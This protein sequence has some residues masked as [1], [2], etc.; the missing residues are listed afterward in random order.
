MAV[1]EGRKLWFEV[2]GLAHQNNRCF[3]KEIDEQTSVCYLCFNDMKST[4]MAESIL[5]LSVK[6][7][8]MVKDGS[9]YHIHSEEKKIIDWFYDTAKEEGDW[10]NFANVIDLE[11][12]IFRGFAFYIYI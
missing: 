4:S 8:K 1:C 5:Q 10:R 2:N 9:S 6:E 12:L 7:S 11:E 3:V